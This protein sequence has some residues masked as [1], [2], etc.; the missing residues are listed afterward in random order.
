MSVIIAQKEADIRKCW[1]VMAQLRPH[2]SE[3]AFVAAVR[4]QSKEG[5]RLACIRRKGRVVAVA[6]FR[7]LHNL[8][9]G[10]LCYVD[11][12]VTDEAVRSKGLGA[13]LLSWIREHARAG[14][15]RRL[16]LDSGVQRHAAHRFYF[17]QRMVITFYHFGQELDGVET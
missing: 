3:D 1:P 9:A 16:E 14:G 2:L 17:G 12:L 15:C 8:S 4:R 13:E 10:R 5:Y 6:G 7:M 11:D